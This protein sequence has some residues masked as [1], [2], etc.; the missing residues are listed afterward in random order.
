MANTYAIKQY[1]A[2]IFLFSFA[3]IAM[4]M[5]SGDDY[6]VDLHIFMSL[7]YGKY[8]C[9]KTIQCQYFPVFFRQDC[10]VHD[11]W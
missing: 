1:N 5:M 9:N 2:N 3:R 7:R 4:C 6:S 10:D 8:I 11:E